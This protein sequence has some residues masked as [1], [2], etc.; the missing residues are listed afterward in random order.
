VD[1]ALA[2]DVLDAFE[3]LKADHD[4][5]FEGEALAVLFEEGLQGT[6]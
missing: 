3:H 4:D 6:A 1:E 2:V 5:G